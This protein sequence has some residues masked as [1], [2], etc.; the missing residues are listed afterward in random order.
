MS[1]GGITLRQGEKVIGIVKPSRAKFFWSYFL[2][3]FILLGCSF[4][5]FWLANRGRLGIFVIVSCFLAALALFWRAWRRNNANFWIL[6]NQRIV[7]VEKIGFLKKN[8]TAEELVYISSVEIRRSGLGHYIFNCGD[9]VLSAG[10]SD[11]SFVLPYA[12]RPEILIEDLRILL[13]ARQ[14]AKNASEDT[15]L[16]LE[17]IQASLAGLSDEELKRVRN[18]ANDI[19]V[20]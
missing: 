2:A 3:I 15:E 11:F 4:F 8:I 7:D 9:V 1:L 17:E 6:T 10:D 19:L 16:S 13:P 12:R 18:F 14:Q 20:E 5:S